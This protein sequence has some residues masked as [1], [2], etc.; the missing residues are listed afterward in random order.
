MVIIGQADASVLHYKQWMRVYSQYLH[1]FV[2]KWHLSS[3]HHSSS[4]LSHHQTLSG[5][6]QT[7]FSVHD[8]L[9]EDQSSCSL[10]MSSSS[11]H[12]LSLMLLYL[13]FPHRSTSVRRETSPDQ[14]GTCTHTGSS[15]SRWSTQ[16][17]TVVNTTWT[18]QTVSSVATRRDRQWPERQ[19]DECVK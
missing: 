14:D 18:K 9:Q 17:F 7:L 16:S 4:C 3:V 5:P 2:V 15:M 19:T 13:Q 1:L 11:V 12:Q 6:C 8:S 10:S